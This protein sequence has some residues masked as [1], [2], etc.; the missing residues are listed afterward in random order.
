MLPELIR[1]LILAEK[2]YFPELR[3]PSGDSVQMHGWDGECKVESGTDQIPAGW[4]GWEL[5]TDQTPKSKADKDYKQRTKDALHLKAPETTFVFVTPRRWA[6]K[7]AWVKQ[8][9]AERHWRDVRAY[10]AV[11]LVQWIERFPGVGLWLAKLIGKA[12]IGV[13]ELGEVWREWSLSTKPRLSTDLV[14]ADRDDEA[15]KLLQWLYGEPAAMSVQ[16]EAPGEAIAF[17]Y[18]AIEQLPPGYRDFFHTRAVVAADANTARSLADVPSPLIIILEEPEPGLSMHLVEKGHYVCLAFGSDAGTPA[19]LLPL[20][21]PTRYA[22]EHEL[23]KMGMERH[24][25]Q[26]F[27]HDSAR[28]LTIL[29]HLIPSA[30][31]YK[32]PDWASPE[33]ARALLPALLAGA[34]DESQPGDVTILEEL[35]GLPY[36]KITAAL[37]PLLHLTDSP[38]RKA[39]NTWKIASPR[40]AWFRVARYI[41]STDLDRFAK[42]SHAVLT[43]VDPRFN[44]APDE[45]WLAGIKGEKPKY[46]SL[47]RTGISEILVLL[48]AFG[49][50]VLSVP[51]ADARGVLIVRGLLH[52]ADAVRW[53]SLSHQLQVLAEA[54][55]E[56]FM[57]AVEDSLAKNDAPILKLFA[58][59][60][61]TFGA[62]YHADLLWALETLAWSPD[63]LWPAPGLDDTRLS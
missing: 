36:D 10:D 17:L 40:D 57:S 28:S 8:H 12:P 16:G 39:G 11:D 27:A 24:E 9:R 13:Q 50:Q 47:L 43:S 26:N 62:A 46:S 35:A 7:Q 2:G 3:F 25:A 56:E 49:K 34:W 51:H 32:V 37:T 63:Y 30:P 19:D 14:L 20:K 54:S 44:M 33:T 23:T 59:D 52:D 1:R 42:A 53:W 29:R 5:G 41:T 60:G 48:N 58:E 31:G 45:R 15:T 22:I 61:G 18:A 38:L 4:S 21:R 6:Q 55:P